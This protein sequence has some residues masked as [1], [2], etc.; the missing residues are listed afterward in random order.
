MASL[1]F[2][3]TLRK[4]RVRWRA[5]NKLAVHNRIFSGSRTFI[6]KTQAIR[7][8]AEI[9][10]Q[11]N[12][13][14]TGQVAPSESIDGV[15]A[16]FQRHI[17]RHIDRTQE[18]Y[19]MVLNRFAES[20]PKRVL[21]ITEINSKHIQEYLYQLR[22]KKLSNRTSNA[23]LTAVKSFCKFYAR[24][25]GIT[26]PAQAVT[27]LKES[28]PDARFLSPEEYK[29]IINAA[30]SMG[31][32]RFLFLAHTGLRAMEFY[33]L[34]WSCLSY[35]NS[36]ITIIGKGRKQR[37]VPLNK[38][39]REILKQMSRGKGRIFGCT[40]NAVW[41]QCNR[42]AEKLEIE[43]FGPHS[44]RHWFA[45]QLLIK[46]IPIKKVSLLLGHKSVRTTEQ[47]YAHILPADLANV[48]DVLD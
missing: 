2:D 6:E 32:D 9:E 37:T 16:D 41:L 4:W 48:T 20:L 10:N 25:F 17:K 44:F 38:T 3:K 8:F 40:P 15:L 13:W 28:P 33:S 43:S 31:R 34:T 14:R 26:N 24:Y 36:S 29:R 27:M 46:G 1:G 7:F 45:T 39:C 19:K 18:H 42:L 30:T 11:E 12:Q 22:D 23:H 5:T 21:R 47:C 35:D